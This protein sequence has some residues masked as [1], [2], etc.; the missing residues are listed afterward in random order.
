MPPKSLMIDLGCPSFICKPCLAALRRAPR[1]SAIVALGLRKS[2]GQATGERPPQALGT[3]RPSAAAQPSEDAERLRTLRNL[4]LLK[5]SEPAE[6]NVK[7]NYFEEA[8]GGKLRRLKGQDEFAASLIDP[9]GELAGQLEEMEQSL[10]KVNSIAKVL[11]ESAFEGP[12]HAPDQNPPSGDV[13]TAYDTMADMQL[14]ES[15]ITGPAVFLLRL[16]EKLQKSAKCL[17]SGRLGPKERNRLWK[18]YS[19]SKTALC[20]NW[21]VVPRAAWELLWHVLAADTPDNTNRM[22][23]IYTLTRDMNVAGVPMSRERQLLA[24][25]SM[26]IEGW[27]KE[28]IDNHRRCVATIGTNPETFVEFW[29]LGLRMHCQVGD[30]ERAER[31]ANIIL[32]SPQKSDPRFLIPSSEPTWTARAKAQTKHMTST[33]G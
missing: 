8:K 12:S 14:M 1:H 11:E 2:S 17:D 28:A 22:A 18:C 9:G 13:E 16:N 32:E 25:E 6:P 30:V 5:G 24:V 21:N 7:V 26:F 10:E 3:D 15:Y 33:T 31:I 29:Q 20:G 4:G 19:D 27:K 23:R